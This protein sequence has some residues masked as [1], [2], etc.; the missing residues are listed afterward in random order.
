M[1]PC[2]QVQVPAEAPET[3][4]GTRRGKIRHVSGPLCDFL[5]LG[6]AGTICWLAGLTSDG[7]M[8]LAS[9]PVLLIG[10]LYVAS[11]VQGGGWA[12][13]VRED[14]L[15]V[16]LFGA[17]VIATGGHLGLQAIADPPAVHW[18][19]WPLA[20]AGA[21]T[22]RLLPGFGP[23]S[24][25]RHGL[26]IG[27]R[28]SDISLPR[29]MVCMARV[30]LDACA[31]MGPTRLNDLVARLADAAGMP[32]HRIV[33]V[34]A[35][36][37]REEGLATSLAERF[38]DAGL[39]V[40]RIITGLPTQSLHPQIF[41]PVGGDVALIDLPPA[42]PTRPS[43]VKRMLDLVLGLS[44]LIILAPLLVGL[45]IWIRVTDPGPVFYVQRRVG[46]NG[47]RFGCLK[48]RSMRVNAE[49]RLAD[50]M[51]RDP[52]ARAEWAMHQK[53]R[54]DPRITRAGAF[55]RATSLDELPQLLNVVRGD[56]S[57]VGPRPVVAPEIE[58]YAADRSYARSPAF[59]A[60]TSMRP[61]LTGLWQV[62]GRAE[63]PYDERIRLDLWYAANRSL[64][65]DVTLLIR[66]GFVMLAHRGS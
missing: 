54:E 23:L 24:R 9:T 52:R 37:D 60:Y 17:A 10:V 28:A 41:R 53:L 18:M 5:G 27:G 29:G 34:L 12:P 26:V 43:W 57:L 8:S 62:S 45:A 39:P 44:F 31:D 50:L 58:G 36:S 30:D 33:V 3:A 4:L 55:L 22:L 47:R 7:A 25:S 65:L 32:F 64:W 38:R 11:M 2:Q 66:T 40:A 20:A 16:R 15:A 19:L 13:W 42:G 48:F 21:L 63:M 14:E 46:L 49:A 56:M 59:D 61:G 1:P 6:L 51:A 35:P